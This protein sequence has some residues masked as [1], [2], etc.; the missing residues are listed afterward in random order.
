MHLEPSRTNWNS[1]FVAL[2]FFGQSKCKILLSLIS[3][4]WWFI[5]IFDSDKLPKKDKETSGT[6]CIKTWNL[7]DI[8]I[9]IFAVL[10]KG[11][12]KTC[13]ICIYI[14]IYIIY[15]YIYIY[16]FVFTIIRHC[17]SHCLTCIKYDIEWNRVE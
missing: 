17:F 10:N 3:L 14:C 1:F 15:V 16:N 9:K 8:L 7:S 4:R 2:T 5:Q 12:K 11:I 13:L 6:P